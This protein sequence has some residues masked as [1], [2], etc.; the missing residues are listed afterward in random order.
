MKVKLT[1]T[2]EVEYE[3][4]EEYYKDCSSYEEMLALDMSN[5]E[6]DP[7]IFMDMDCAK[8]NIKGELL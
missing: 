8:V 1:M 5:M 3:I 2:V 4:K 6:D 7:Y